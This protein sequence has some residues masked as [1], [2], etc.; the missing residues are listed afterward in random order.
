MRLLLRRSV[1]EH[2][3]LRWRTEFVLWARFEL[4]DEERILVRKYDMA[5]G[6]LTIE[7][8]WQDVRR[9]GLYAFFPALFVAYLLATS[10]ATYFLVLFGSYAII[11]WVIYEQIREAIKI[12]DIINGREFK[13]RSAIL[14]MRRERRITG[15]AAAFIH[16]LEL[17]RKGEGI[18]VVE[19]GEEHEG[20]LRLV[21]DTY[22]PA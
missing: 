13:H 5:K 16:L 3:L 6:Y 14:M 9:A 19:I 21:T 11:T 1:R 12:L 20:A 8:S 2:K 18:D 4:T 22:A 17:L 7:G 15:Y 10:L